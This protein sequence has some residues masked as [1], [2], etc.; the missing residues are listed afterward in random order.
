MISGVIPVEDLKSRPTLINKNKFPMQDVLAI[1]RSFHHLYVI[2]PKILAIYNQHIEQDAAMLCV[3]ALHLIQCLQF[4][5]SLEANFECLQGSGSSDGVLCSWYVPGS[6]VRSF[7]SS[8]SF[9]PSVGT[10]S[11]FLDGIGNSEGPDSCVDDCDDL[12]LQI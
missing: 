4:Q 7:G 1:P 8:H 2:F 9:L 5:A 6:F 10:L 12:K 11:G 3:Q